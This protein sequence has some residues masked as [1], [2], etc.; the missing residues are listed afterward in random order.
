[1]LGHAQP[2]PAPTERLTLDSAVQIALAHNRQVEAAQLQVARADEELAAA[3]TRRLPSFDTSATGSQLLMP[4]SFSFPRGAF[5]EI[6][7]VGPFPAAD[8][9]VTSPQRPTLFVSAQMIQPISQLFRIGL[10]IKAA[11]AT[12]DV[13]HERSRAQQ[14]AIV[15]SVRRLYLAIQQTESA[16]EASDQAIALYRELDR[17]VAV[18]VS[19]KTA[20]RADAMDVEVRLAQEELTRLTRAHTL[21]TQKEQ[22]NALLGRDVATSFDT[23]R[24][25]PASLLE[26]DGAATRAR[27][28]ADR[29]DVREARIR[30]QQAELDRR[31]KKAERMPDVSLAVGYSSNLNIEVLPRNLATVGVQVKW[32]PF[33]WGRRSRELAAKSHALTMARLALRETEDRVVLEINSTFR[34]LVETRALLKVAALARDTAR[35]RL[36]VTSNQFRVQ[37]AMLADVLRV[38]AELADSDDRYQQALVAFSTARADFE[39][40]AGEDVIP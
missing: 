19:E 15:N 21:T 32:Q 34:R 7:G 14:A 3:R 33:D 17:T 16:V 18:R 37:A 20:L 10:G 5:G 26:I 31:I 28:L 40:A 4:V 36:R 24:V 29:P 13:E 1:V 12:R 23:D 38:R 8:T 25:A 30:L 9:E 11:A 35:E 39:H 6:P 2:A 27:A 22:L